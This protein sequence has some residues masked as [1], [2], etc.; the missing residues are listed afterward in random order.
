[1]RHPEPRTKAELRRAEYNA[2]SILESDE[3][4]WMREEL[5]RRIGVC[6]DRLLNDPVELVEHVRGVVEGLNM[7]LS[8][9]QDELAA[10]ASEL[11][12]GE[13]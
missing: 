2:R 13:S 5:Q 6:M 9:P 3:W 11:E 1:M 8:L 10:A 7:A 4:R 12:L